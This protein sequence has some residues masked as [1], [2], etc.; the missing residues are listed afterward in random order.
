MDM[1]CLKICHANFPNW[2]TIDTCAKWV[3]GIHEINTRCPG[4]AEEDRAPLFWL[5]EVLIKPYG[6]RPKERGI[7]H[8]SVV[9]TSQALEKLPPPQS[10]HPLMHYIQE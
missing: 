2:N 7:R 4:R 3:T 10:N 9:S 6:R 5:S 8:M 1:L